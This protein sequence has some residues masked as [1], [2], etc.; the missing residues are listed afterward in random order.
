MRRRG[1]E[2]AGGGVGG[3]LK[4]F[5]EPVFTLMTGWLSDGKLISLSEIERK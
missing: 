5:N 4:S 2:A 3:S 1:S